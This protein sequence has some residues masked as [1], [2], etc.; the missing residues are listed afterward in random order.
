M[1]NSKDTSDADRATAEAKFKKKQI[2]AEQGSEARIE[3]AAGQKAALERMP[4]LKELR[5]AREAS[6]KEAA[7]K[8]STKPGTNARAAGSKGNRPKSLP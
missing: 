2:A 1:A 7:T 4:K 3:Y 8:K 5:L 6:D